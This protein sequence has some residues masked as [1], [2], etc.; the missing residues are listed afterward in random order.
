MA[1]QAMSHLITNGGLPMATVVATLAQPVDLSLSTFRLALAKQLQSC[2]LGYGIE[3][4]PRN[5]NGRAA[6][7]IA[8]RCG[9]WWSKR[10]MK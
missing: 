3:F 4:A 6:S 10:G 9:H 5:Q 7:C 8:C 2:L 1:Q